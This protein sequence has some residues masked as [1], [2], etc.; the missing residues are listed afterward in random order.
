M[1]IKDETYLK[2]IKIFW[3]RTLFLL[4]IFQVTRLFFYIFNYSKFS[5]LSFGE[6]VW[7]FIVGLRFDIVSIGIFNSVFILL[8]IL[9]FNFI[10]KRTYQFFLKTLF[11]LINS[12]LLI[13]NL[14][15]T[16]YF[17]FTQKRSTSEILQVVSGDDFKNLLFQY[18]RDYWFVFLLFIFILYA[19]IR[20]YPKASFIEKTKISFKQAAFRFIIF[21]GI[22]AV[23]TAAIRG[24]GHRP[25]AITSAAKFTNANAVS[26]VLNTPFTIINT[27]NKESLEPLH[28]YNDDT[29]SNIFTPIH[30][31]NRHATRKLNVV[32][33][34]LE[35]FGK[36]YSAYFNP[37]TQGYM[38]FIDS[39]CKESLH[40]RY[41]FANGKRSMDAVASIF[42]SMPSLMNTPYLIS[43]YASNKS[44]GLAS[45]LKDWGYKT[46]FMH[47]GA[48]G[49]MDFDKFCYMSGFEKYFGK[50][51]YPNKKDF[52]GLWGI[53][54][55]PYLQWSVEKMSE[56]E[57]P[58]FNA[59]FT[60]SSHHPYTI[61]EEYKNKF[62]KGT[63]EIHESI[64]YA[65]FALKQFFKKAQNTDWF[66]NTLFIF[67][68][69]HTSISE[70]KYYQRNL[71]TYAIPIFF[72]KS[73]DS[74][75]KGLSQKIMQQID[76]MPSVLDYLGYQ[77]KIY[78]FGNSIFDNSRSEYLINYINNQ[79]LFANENLLSLSDTSEVNALYL[80]RKDSM[81]FNN[82]INKPETRAQ[83]DKQSD[84]LFKAIVQTYNK[85]LIQ[86]KAFINHEP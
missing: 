34:I 79:Y 15:D 52:D 43:P 38:P 41:S 4:L 78:A 66:K 3:Y 49:T 86:N 23:T 12:I 25:I 48:N 13:S 6:T 42:N 51:E 65:D 17:Q 21:I 76:I 7:A 60:L 57:Q 67:T 32:I 31:Y 53:F 82:L 26:L 37:K 61:P 44:S 80:Y 50:D 58:F 8:S 27:I 45:V 30:Q 10:G 9:P 2:Q 70:D 33:F 63:L 28:Y 69:D 75:L 18:I 73:G 62:S 39:L 46:S 72:Y 64:G 11:I 81:L 29:L 16:V 47:G 84:S 35:S 85:D 56:F 74:T 19:L 55:E 40:F 77:Q 1:T 71:G 83:Y 22:I 24:F 14:M 59:I 68:A 20:F 5:V 54:D 36:E